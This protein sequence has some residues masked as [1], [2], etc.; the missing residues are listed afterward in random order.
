LIILAVRSCC[1]TQMYPYAHRF[2][3]SRLNRSHALSVSRCIIWMFPTCLIWMFPTSP[4]GRPLDTTR[5]RRLIGSL[6]FIVHFQQKSPIF[7]GSFVENNLQL[8]GSY[9]SS[10][11]CTLSRD[12]TT[13]LDKVNLCRTAGKT[14]TPRLM[15]P[16]ASLRQENG[17]C[18][19]H[20][21]SIYASVWIV[22]PPHPLQ[23]VC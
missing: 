15:A 18:V 19:A 23:I 4:W 5:W 8:R 14:V 16:A 17:A 10:P 11:P 2:G 9:E 22:A 7:S 20:L 12:V 21:I 6:I 1:G 3:A 13:V